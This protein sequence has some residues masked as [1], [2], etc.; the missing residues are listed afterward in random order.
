MTRE[1]REQLWLQ[2]RSVLADNPRYEAVIVGYY[3]YEL[4]L[5]TLSE[6][7]QTPVR[8]IYVLKSRALARLR[9]N[10]DFV[11]LFADALGA[12]AGGKT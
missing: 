10:E 9:A 5:L 8:N 3:L 6:M 1:L 11:E 2:V 4:P 12:L 7:L